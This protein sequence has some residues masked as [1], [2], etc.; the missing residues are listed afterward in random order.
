MGTALQIFL[1]IN[2]FIIGAATALAVQHAYE[3]YRPQKPEPKKPVRPDTPI[4]RAIREQLL[5]EATAKYQRALDSAGAEI[6]QELK[7]TTKRLDE[8]LARIGREVIEEEMKRY[9][10]TLEDLR[11]QTKISIGSAQT[12][13]AEHQAELQAS[14][15]ARQ[16]ELEAKLELD[17]AAKKTQLAAE[18]DTK[19]ADAVTSF[20]IET[21]GHNIDLGAQVPYLLATLEEH[22]AEILQGV[23]G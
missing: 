15:A 1:I 17:I 18:L 10:T 3:H 22:K 6:E 9:R 5:A 2:V 14:F 11:E 16:K 8:K 12:N 23:K 7:I 21:M 20:L 19:L 13:V 4:P